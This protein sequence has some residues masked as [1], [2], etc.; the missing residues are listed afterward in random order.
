MIDV[1]KISDALQD[2]IVRLKSIYKGGLYV[3]PTQRGSYY[4]ASGFKGMWGKLVTQAKDLKVIE[5]GFTFHDL[6]AYYVTQFK[7][8][9][10][11]RLPDIHANP[12]TTA[13]IYDRTKE[14]K[15]RAI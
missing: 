5:G 2:L 11:G 1:I 13:R 7:R 12:Q 6:R 15:R 8:S 3:F 14:V 4:T 9:N 10:D